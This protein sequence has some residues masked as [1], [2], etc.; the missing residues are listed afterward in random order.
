MV[1]AYIKRRVRKAMKKYRRKQ[2]NQE[3][4]MVNKSLQPIPNRY[5][6][7][8]KYATHVNTT[9]TGAY[10]F[11]INSLFDPD[12][13]GI[14]HQPYGYDNLTFCITV[15]ASYPVVG[16]YNS[17]L[18]LMELQLFLRVCLTMTCFL[19]GLTTARWPKIPALN[20]SLIIQEPPWRLYQESPI[21]PS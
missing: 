9:A 18:L 21:Y 5:I 14:G 13:T 6:C 15:I 10:V 7:K 8:M 4:G 3:L 12:N 16:A 1:K 11:R 19:R 17:R 20:M 2:R